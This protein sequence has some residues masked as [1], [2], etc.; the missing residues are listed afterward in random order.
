MKALI[1]GTFA[2]SALVVCASI[3]APEPAVVPGPGLWTADVKFA[4]PQQIVLRSVTD[5]KPIR[6][7]YVLM[8]LTNN[9][10][11]DVGFYPKCDLMTD[12]FRITRAGKDVAPLVFGQI[13]LR[14]Q[15]R[16]PLLESLAKT[17]SR[18]LQGEDNAKDLAIIWPD[19]DGRAKGI[20]IFVAGLSNETVA[21]EHPVAK[22]EDGKP[23]KVYLRKT[24]ELE[25]TVKGDPAT[26]SAAD[27]AFKA[28]RWIM[29]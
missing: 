16:Y 10:G 15:A 23:V 27:L 8:S 14:H 26:R 3:G 4:H 19:F 28:K 21:V 12:T 29:R 24:L 5:N 17:D 1:Y 25:Y 22:D 20:K 13:K 18:L 7:W 2:V 6:F 11:Q 9:S